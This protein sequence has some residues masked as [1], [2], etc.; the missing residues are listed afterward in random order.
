MLSLQEPRKG[1]ARVRVNS[2]PGASH[3]WREPKWPQLGP[4]PRG[5][6]VGC[7][8]GWAGLMAARVRPTGA[9]LELARVRVFRAFRVN[10]VP[11][12]RQKMDSNSFT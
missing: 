1:L 4:N 7:R 12:A 8:Q 2:A 9:K 6:L 11:G 3:R 10:S 5:G